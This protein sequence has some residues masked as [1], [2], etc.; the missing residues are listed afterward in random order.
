MEITFWIMEKSWNCVF[1]FCGNPVNAGQ[2]YCRML[3]LSNTFDL[4]L[5]IIGLENQFMVRKLSGVVVLF[6]HF[7]AKYVQLCAR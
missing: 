2:K 6:Y 3:S 7:I 4:H 5:G 1:E